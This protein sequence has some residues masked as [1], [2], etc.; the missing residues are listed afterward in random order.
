[1]MSWGYGMFGGFGMLLFWG[2]IIV[3]AALLLRQVTGGGARSRAR[4]ICQP[5]RKTDPLSAPN[6]DPTFR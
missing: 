2:A 5:A 1:M 3:L 6:I 4:Q